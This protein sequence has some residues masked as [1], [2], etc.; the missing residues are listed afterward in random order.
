MT[1]PLLHH[2]FLND[3]R[4]VQGTGLLP[5]EIRESSGSK[6]A[7]TVIHCVTLPART[8]PVIRDTISS[9]STQHLIGLVS[10]VYMRQCE[11]HAGTL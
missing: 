9:E 3:C 11:Q 7:L 2:R 1:S 8:T 6:Y 10:Q 4:Y 5:F